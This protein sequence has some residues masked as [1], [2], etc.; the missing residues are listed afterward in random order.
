[1]KFL[2]AAKNKGNFNAHVEDDSEILYKLENPLS[3]SISG[4]KLLL[5]K[6]S[7]I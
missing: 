5:K 3:P 2:S 4:I 1:M 6:F 7:K